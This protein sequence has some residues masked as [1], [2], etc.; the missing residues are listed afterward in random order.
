MKERGDYIMENLLNRGTNNNN[1]TTGANVNLMSEFEAFYNSGVAKKVTITEGTYTGTVKDITKAE[2]KDY[3][4]AII[5]TE[6][7]K[8][9]YAIFDLDK[10]LFEYNLIHETLYTE[11]K[12]V[13][14]QPC[15]IYVYSVKDKLR[16]TQLPV[17]PEGTHTCNFQGLYTVNT[18][19]IIKY[20]YNGIMHFDLR[21]FNPEPK[22]KELLLNTFRALA[23]R[24][25]YP[26]AEENVQFNS[27]NEKIGTD[28]I[29]NCVVPEQYNNRY[30]NY[31]GPKKDDTTTTP[32]TVSLS[33]FR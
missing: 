6:T 17:L 4:T 11:S 24:L 15:T 16:Y 13:I 19:F 31:W 3:Y 25:G 26:I 7:H 22:A 18:T 2:G 33:S 5:E 10:F 21:E 8:V 9:N 32:T 1:N 28:I 30:I 20:E 29:I 23:E 27:F 14:G 12:Q